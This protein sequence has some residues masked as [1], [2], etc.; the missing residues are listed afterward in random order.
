MRKTIGWLLVLAGIFLLLY[1]KIE[2]LTFQQ[3][4]QQI[5]NAF[6]QLGEWEGTAIADS[7]EGQLAEPV[8]EEELAEGIQGILSI[9][10]IDL[11]VAVFEE[12]TPKNLLK[13]VGLIE[14]DKQIGIQ[15]IGLAGHRSTTRGKQFNRLGEVEVGDQIEL[16]TRDDIYTFDVINSFTVHES[17]VSV[18]EDKDAPMLTLVTC[19]PL[20]SKNPPNRL[21]V[22]A[23]L[24]KEEK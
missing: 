11:E 22:Q 5:I 19:T 9:D 8:V 4:Q 20:G 24:V 16:R 6:T 21:I 10:K 1:P 15:N 14:S 18:L 3:E 17:E 7:E 23:K 2:G 13:G 12:A